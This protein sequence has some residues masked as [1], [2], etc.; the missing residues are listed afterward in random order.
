[1]NRYHKNIYFPESDTNPLTAFNEKVNTKAWRINAH[2]LERVMDNLT[3]GSLEKLML[4]IKDLKLERKTIFEYYSSRYGIEKICYRV[5]YGE[6]S[7]L[8]L[9]V[10]SNKELITVYFNEVNDNHITLRKELYI[11]N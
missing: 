4:F 10:G 9:V 2:S 3:F 7:D 8:I 11:T 1:M 5:N 6:Y